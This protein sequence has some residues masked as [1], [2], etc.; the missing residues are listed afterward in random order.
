MN[1][2]LKTELE[3][4]GKRYLPKI[5]LVA[6]ECAPLAKTGGLADVVGTLPKS[7][8]KLGMD[9]RVIIPYH[10]I[11][12]D[13]YRSQ[14]VHMF[15]FYCD[16][17]WRR[18]Y[19]G[20]EKLELDGVIIYLVDNE[21]YF[22]D[23]IYRG[24]DP[25]TQQY[26][27]FTR[28]V[29]DAIPNLDF[30]PSV[31]HCNDWQSAMIPMLAKT[32]YSGSIQEGLKYLLTIHNIAY[33]G[34]CGFE[35][36]Q[37]LL[38]VDKKY[39]TSEFMELDGCANFLKAGCVFADALNTVSPSYAEEIKTPYYSE[40]LEGILNARS[41]ELFGIVNGIDTKV[42]NPH[43]DPVIP[44]K[45]DK[46]HM[47]GKAF[48]KK[49]LQEHMGLDE[50]ADVPIVSMVTRMT[51][52]KGF[53]LVERMLDELMMYNDMQFMLLG[54]GDS[55][56]ESFMRGAES[57]YK[58][59]VCSYI[60]YNDNLAHLIYA[61]SD[62]YLMPSRFEPCGI[63]QML[64]MR[65]GTLPI[66][67]ETGGLKDTV[68]P[69]N[70]YT[71]EGNGFSFTN[72]NAHEMRECILGALNVYRDKETMNKLIYSAMSTD[73]GFELSALEYAKHYI[74]LI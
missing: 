27:F 28:A 21:G 54:S 72:F 37:D 74:W 64:A 4:K 42:F 14:V 25:E 35:F 39:Y 70:K 40:G 33:Q 58:G 67:R 19:V 36:V 17:G 2:I 71:G 29:L 23:K 51:E 30:K 18:E 13:R 65:Y 46:G 16:L 6:S 31:I 49:V 47:K 41:H 68:T 10:R 69:Y 59:R 8:K 1:Q 34:K 7:L 22:G 9:A 52:Q 57:R 15:D 20:I 26:A 48:C 66:V 32:Q 24:G 50:R 43:S 53:A 61:G 3:K 44:S 56:F 12:K 11:I 5:L 38:R 62:F 63:S 45:Y 73:F 60:G 55:N